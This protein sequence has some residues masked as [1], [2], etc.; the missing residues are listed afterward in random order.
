MPRVDEIRIFCSYSHQDTV[1]K[2]ELV[3]HL[4]LLRK[5]LLIQAWHDGELKGGQEW[6][7]EIEDH[8]RDAHVI[9][10]LISIDF[11]RSEFVREHEL[12][13][14]LERHKQGAALV[15]PV[16]LRP[17]PWDQAGLDF[18]QALPDGLRPVVLWSPQDLAYVNVCEGLLAAVLAW[19]GDKKTPIRSSDRPTAMRRRVVDLALSGRVPVGKS[20][21]L[22]VMV[23]PVGAGGL[24]AVLLVDNRMGLSPEEVESTRSFPLEFPRDNAGRLTPLELTVSVDSGD[25][26]CS[27]PRKTLSIPPKGE[28][29]VCVFL[30]QAGL[31]GPLILAVEI[32]Y[33]GRIILSQVMRSTG[34]ENFAEPFQPR[35]QELPLL[36]PGGPEAESVIVGSSGGSEP[37]AYARPP[38]PVESAP[39]TGGS[40]FP[41]SPILRI[42]LIL[43][44]L[45]VA[46][47]AWKVFKHL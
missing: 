23:R 19:Q 1:L 44:L 5:S 37:Y 17:V 25:F 4:E 40:S 6:Q 42:I 34:V 9:L 47:L 13:I 45:V 26:L 12:P 21:I 27:A 2:D 16:I 33:Q 36:D 11:L 10:L 20:T 14:A 3:K 41:S 32:S 28:S 7:R 46:F 24:R 18:L 31:R 35:V 22:A 43:L 38:L 8:M 30:L 39:S 15:I 29:A